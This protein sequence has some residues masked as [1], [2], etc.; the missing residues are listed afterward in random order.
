MPVPR[1]RLYPRST[2]TIAP[3]LLGRLY[4]CYS[5]FFGPRA[6]EHTLRELSIAASGLC[7]S[8]RLEAVSSPI[9]ASPP[10]SSSST[11]LHSSLPPPRAQKC[12]LPPQ[13]SAPPSLGAATQP[14]SPNCPRPSSPSFEALSRTRPHRSPCRRRSSRETRERPRRSRCVHFVSLCWL[15]FV[16]DGL[17]R[18]E[19]KEE[20]RVACAAGR[21]SH[22]WDGRGFLRLSGV[23]RGFK[24]PRAAFTLSHQL[25]GS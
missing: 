16:G 17:P 6:P 15:D 4:P 13:Q 20:R 24:P 12:H 21:R 3:T 5:L 7:A 9:S 25:S 22:E 1:P 23:A 11:S 8:A 14:S 2:L 18:R 19:H 10:T